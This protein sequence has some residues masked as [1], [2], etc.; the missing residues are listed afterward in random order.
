LWRLRHNTAG[1]Q[2]SERIIE[3]RLLYAYAEI[4]SG[5]NSS[6]AIGEIAFDAGFP[7]QSYF[8]RSF[9][10]RFGVSPREV[11]DN[12]SAPQEQ[13]LKLGANSEQVYEVYK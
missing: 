8:N 2:F 6:R 13:K 9:R 5:L 12:G 10:K 1:K 7:N 4:A 11:R 3:R